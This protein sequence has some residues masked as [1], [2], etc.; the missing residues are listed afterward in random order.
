MSLS[1]LASAY[2]SP[3]NDGIFSIFAFA[4]SL[5]YSIKSFS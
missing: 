1:G 4:Y 2:F 5:A 3:G